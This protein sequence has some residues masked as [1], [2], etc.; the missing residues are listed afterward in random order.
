MESRREAASRC[1]CSTAAV[2]EL[3]GQRDPHHGFLSQRKRFGHTQLL[4][5]QA[6]P[7]GKDDPPKTRQVLLLLQL[8]RAGWSRSCRTLTQGQ[9]CAQGEHEAQN[10][11]SATNSEC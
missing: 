6:L 4:S 2:P 9:A 5:K 7:V 11:S 10:C 1:G 8:P 3:Q